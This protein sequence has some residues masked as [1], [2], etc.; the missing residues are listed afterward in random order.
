MISQQWSVFQ[1]H[2]KPAGLTAMTTWAGLG[3]PGGMSGPNLLLFPDSLF[4]SDA[5]HDSDLERHLLWD[6]A[7]TMPGTVRCSLFDSS[8]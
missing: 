3:V 8:F 5:P 4:G 2:E 7:L 6:L 1:E